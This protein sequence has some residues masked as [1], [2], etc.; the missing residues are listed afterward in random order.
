MG[1]LQ[2]EA[3][4]PLSSLGCQLLNTLMIVFD[5]WQMGKLFFAFFIFFPLL[6]LSLSSS[7]LFFLSFWQQ[8]FGGENLGFQ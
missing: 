5:L 6:S 8:V 3:E 2:P 1:A 7:L 4:S